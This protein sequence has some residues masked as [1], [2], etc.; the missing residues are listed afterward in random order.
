MAAEL[1]IL[2]RARWRTA[3]LAEVL[4]GRRQLLRLVQLV[5]VNHPGPPT[6]LLPPK[7]YSSEPLQALFHNEV[8][9]FLIVVRRLS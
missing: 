4:V 6:F 8:D 2:P 3:Q 5:R 1:P 9:L 7:L